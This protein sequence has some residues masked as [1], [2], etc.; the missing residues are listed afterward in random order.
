MTEEVREFGYA[1]NHCIIE[2]TEEWIPISLS[3][4][5]HGQ[6]SNGIYVDFLYRVQSNQEDPKH[7]LLIK[8]DLSAYAW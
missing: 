3:I 2:S 1:C 4:V 5:L 8:D 6:K 7:M